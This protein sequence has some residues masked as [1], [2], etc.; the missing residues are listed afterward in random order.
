LKLF[1]EQKSGGNKIMN[2]NPIYAWKNFGDAIHCLATGPG[3]IKTRLLSAFLS[4]SCLTSHDIPDE[5]QEQ[6]SQLRSL[7]AATQPK[8]DLGKIKEKLRYMRKDKATQI[9]ELFLS[10]YVQL[11]QM[12]VAY[13]QGSAQQV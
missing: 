3:E 7:L 10:I 11:T 12:C 6:F 2:D 9:A 8:P 13:P 5:I 1:I 4:I